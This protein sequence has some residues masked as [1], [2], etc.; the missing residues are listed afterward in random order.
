MRVSSNPV[1]CPAVAGK[2]KEGDFVRRLDYFKLLQ[3]PIN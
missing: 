3:S 1:A 2:A